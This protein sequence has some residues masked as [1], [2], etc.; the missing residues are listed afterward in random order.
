VNISKLIIIK[1]NEN[2]GRDNVADTMEIG[3]VGLIIVCN[4]ERIS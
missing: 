3:L 1:L 2:S 4:R